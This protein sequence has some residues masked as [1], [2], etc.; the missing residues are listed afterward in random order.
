[1]ELILTALRRAEKSKSQIM[2]ETGLP[3]GIV[4]RLL[5]VLTLEGRV[6]KKGLRYVIM[7]RNGY[8][9]V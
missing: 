7:E 2:N 5:E 9:G 4:S 1:M 8:T 6:R 3:Y